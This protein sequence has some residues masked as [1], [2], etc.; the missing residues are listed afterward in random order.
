MVDQSIRDKRN[1]PIRTGSTKE[2]KKIVSDCGNTEFCFPNTLSMF[3]DAKP[4]GT[5]RVEDEENSLFPEGTVIKWFVISADSKNRKPRK[6][7]YLT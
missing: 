7:I 2:C 6:M 5:L 1:E 4:R 3:P